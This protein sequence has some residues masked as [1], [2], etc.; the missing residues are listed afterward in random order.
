MSAC[1]EKSALFVCGC[2]LYIKVKMLTVNLIPQAKTRVHYN[3]DHPEFNTELN[4]LFKVSFPYK[5]WLDVLIKIIGHALKQLTFHRD[6]CTHNLTGLNGFRTL[7]LFNT[8]L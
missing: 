8:V 1:T 6:R 3:S 5:P 4:V 7:D 2:Y